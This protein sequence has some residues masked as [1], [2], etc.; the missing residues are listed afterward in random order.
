MPVKRLA[1]KNP[2]Q[3]SRIRRLL[4]LSLVAFQALTVITILGLSHLSNERVMLEQAGR[5]LE[6][7]TD[8]AADHTRSFLDNAERT[9]TSTALM[10]ASDVLAV[11]QPARLENFFVSLLEQNR[12]FAGMYIGTVDGDFFYVSRSENPEHAYRVKSMR[13]GQTAGA[14][15]SWRGRTPGSLASDVDPYDTYDPRTRPW[16]EQATGEQRAV[17]TDPYVFF[18]AQ[19]LG[20]TVAAPLHRADGALA[21][22]IG[23][24]LELTELAS[25]LQ[26]LEVSPSGSAFITSSD[27]VLIAAPFSGN[28]AQ[29]A[30][31]NA[32]GLELHSVE[33]LTDYAGREALRLVQLAPEVAGHARS[34]FRIG[35]TDYLV[36]HEPL[37]LAGDRTWLV[38]TFAAEDDFLGAIRIN[39]RNNLLLAAGILLVSMLIGWHLAGSA[40]T[41]VAALHAQ[42][43]RDPLTQLHNRR[44]LQ[45]HAQQ[46]F[47]DARD[48]G[49]SIVAVIVDIDHFKR[50]NDGYGHAVGDEVIIEV[51]QRLRRAARIGDTVARLGGEEFVVLLPTATAEV[52]ATIM[53]RIAEW[54][55]SEPVPTQ[56]GPVAVTFSAGIATPDTAG[57]GFE[58]TLRAADSAL[59]Q[60][61]QTGRDRVVVA[62]TKKPCQGRASEVSPR[63]CSG[64]SAAEIS[65]QAEA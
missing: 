63:G 57:Y 24:D 11:D 35:A 21:G 31:T 41:P 37:V 44:Y 1:E 12:A 30:S 60:A 32:S 38:G 19:R 51:A 53:N 33:S 14:W 52:A 34:M 61:K 10:F 54:F 43:N 3:L 46:L 29:L 2:R 6:T 39:E 4:V 45:R 18:T 47:D 36:D 56:A 64:A 17:W 28:G 8:E 58:E 16:F 15:L 55:R 25:F 40:W 7:A 65:E 20:I 26:A 42:V 59:Y 13:P 22:A 27:G 49:T 23:I 50:I 9:V 62:P 48:N 5:I